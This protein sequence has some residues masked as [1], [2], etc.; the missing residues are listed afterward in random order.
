MIRYSIRIEGFRF[1][2]RIAGPQGQLRQDTVLR[3]LLVLPLHLFPFSRSAAALGPKALN[4][5]MDN[6]L[7]WGLTRF[8]PSLDDFAAY[9]SDEQGSFMKRKNFRGHFTIMNGFQNNDTYKV[10]DPSPSPS[11]SPVDLSS[12]AMAL[13]PT[14]LWVC[15]IVIGLQLIWHA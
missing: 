8:S 5:T 12:G 4:L 3:P 10:P 7:I 13:Q 11:P 14:M 9:H 6:R 15:G 1:S 2:Q